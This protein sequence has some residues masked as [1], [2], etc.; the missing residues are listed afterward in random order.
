MRCVQFTFVNKKDPKSRLWEK[1][2]GL[3]NFRTN[4][5]CEAIIKVTPVT[6]SKTKML[7]RL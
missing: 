6:T 7:E 5:M 1:W 3:I 2:F 4:A